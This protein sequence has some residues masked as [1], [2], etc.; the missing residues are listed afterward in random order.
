MLIDINDN[1]QYTVCSIFLG[2]A[3]LL[4]WCGLLRYLGHFRKYNVS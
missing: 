4:T 3:V 1:T 2:I